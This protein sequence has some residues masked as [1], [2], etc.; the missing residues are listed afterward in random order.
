M[1][2]ELRKHGVR[3]KLHDQPFKVLAVLL[4]HP[5]EVVTR[6]SLCQRLWPADVFVDSEVGLNSAI[7][8]L[9]DALGDSA[10]NPR[11]IETLPRRGY[12]LIVPVEGI[13]GAANLLGSGSD[14]PPAIK[15]SS[16]VPDPSI[17]QSV[18]P[19][20]PVSGSAM[21]EH[22]E[23]IAGPIDSPVTQVAQVRARAKAAAFVAVIV[24]IGVI[25]IASWRFTR[26]KPGPYTIAVLPLK[27]L[28]PDA[29]ND[30]FSDG[31]TD[32]IISNLS[33]IDGLQVKSRTSSFAFKDKVY[34]TRAI[35]SQLN[36]R[37]ILDGSVLRAGD[38]LRVNVQLVRVE[39]DVALWSGH[40]DRE[41]KDIFEVQDEISRS[42]VN[43]LRLNLG[44]GQRRYNTNL[45]A[46][47]SYL[48]ARELVNLTPG[49]DSETIATSIPL[50]EAAIAKD[51]NFAP[52]YAGIADAYA[53]LSATPRT[54]SPEIAYPKMKAACNKA[55][56][57]D[58]LLP[59]A[60]SCMGL[61]LS[62]AHE[63]QEAEKSFRRAFELNPNL[64]RPRQDYAVWVL[65][66]LGKIDEALKELHKARELDPLSLHLSQTI[67][68][69]LLMAGRF[70]EV[71]SS[72]PGQSAASP[73]GF[74]DQV[75]ARALTQKGR[76]NESIP[77]FERLG[78]G[79]E[80]YLGFAYAKA[81]RRAEAE[82]IWAKNPTFPWFEALIYS[83]LGDKDRAIEGLRKMIL[84]QDPRVGFY[85]W[86]PELAILREDPRLNEIRSALNLP[87][88]R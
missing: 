51:P 69:V 38:R 70:D 48:K 26:P 47:E 19:T 80:A 17:Q 60:H 83:G 22:A 45:G 81:G 75:Y 10:E 88:P 87:L 59:E 18:Q 1:S 54:F 74:S 34:D 63:W 2:G 30:Y 14:L 12:R 32:E 46:Y 79:S 84:I 66:P 76:L 39:D 3:I 20:T 86:L 58:P 16:K 49:V 7:M 33:V 23:V 4:E 15:M 44:R 52:A 11:F 78:M 42:I 25:G 5:G 67:N 36:T 73:E 57:L 82:Q 62:R 8:K 24:I 21:R 71:I 6:E 9:R 43:E 28:S 53:Y 41:L 40:Y 31:L 50:F 85:L 35:G 77:I 72:Y 27:N 13:H 64:S 56:E 29:G 65:C 37:L 68:F 55:M 61:V